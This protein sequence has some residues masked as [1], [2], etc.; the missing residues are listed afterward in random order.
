MSQT[1]TIRRTRPG[2]LNVLGQPTPGEVEIHKLVCRAWEATET[3]IA[4]DGKWYAVSMLK[5]RV[6]IEADIA[7]HDNVTISPVG[8]PRNNFVGVVDTVLARHHHQLVT[9]EDYQA[10]P[11]T[12]IGGFSSGF[13]SGFDV[14]RDS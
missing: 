10:V 8:D 7:R 5:M 1:A 3:A 2:P 13:S 11:V 6:P 4:G 14:V 9:I 12:T